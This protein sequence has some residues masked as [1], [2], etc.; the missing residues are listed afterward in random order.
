[1]WKGISLSFDLEY[2]QI[3]CDSPYILLDGKQEQQLLLR[4]MNDF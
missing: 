2:S 1:M 3:F 4:C